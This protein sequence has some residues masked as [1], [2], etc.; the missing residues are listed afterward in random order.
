MVA[1]IKGRA[2]LRAIESS[3]CLI[4]G[5][6]NVVLKR[7]DSQEAASK[8]CRM[9]DRRNVMGMFWHCDSRIYSRVVSTSNRESDHHSMIS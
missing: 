5:K 2:A 6:I 7:K 8:E 9:G 3:G 4:G 1:T